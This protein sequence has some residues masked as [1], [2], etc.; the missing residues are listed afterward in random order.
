[1]D[2]SGT[3]E[4][5]PFGRMLWPDLLR[6][7]SDNGTRNFVHGNSEEGRRWGPGGGTW[8]RWFLTQTVTRPA[9]CPLGQ[10]PTQSPPV[11]VPLRSL[12]LP[13][14][15]RDWSAASSADVDAVLLSPQC[16]ARRRQLVAGVLQ[17][18]GNSWVSNDSSRR[19]R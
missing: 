13:T 4:D 7:T 12:P 2:P 3:S 10:S 1:L 14:F 19:P 8:G 16:C 11:H 17:S 6:K 9:T 15:C 18:W 5:S